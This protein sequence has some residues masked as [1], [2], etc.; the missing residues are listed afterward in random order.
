MEAQNWEA[1]PG[2]TVQDWIHPSQERLKK[3]TEAAAP[4]SLDRP[5]E[6]EGIAAV[7]VPVGLLQWAARESFDFDQRLRRARESVAERAG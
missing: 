2:L 5:H 1:V 6:L 4:A 7:S 3:T